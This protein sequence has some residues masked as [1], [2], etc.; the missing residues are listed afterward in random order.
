MPRGDTVA[1]VVKNKSGEAQVLDHTALLPADVTLKDGTKISEPTKITTRETNNA[2]EELRVADQQETSAPLISESVRDAIVNN[3]KI[4]STR[5]REVGKKLYLT[6]RKEGSIDAEAPVRGMSP[7]EM[8]K[9]LR[10]GK[11]EGSSDYAG[12]MYGAIYADGV[13]PI[14]GDSTKIPV[15]AIFPREANEGSMGKRGGY[16]EVS[17]NPNT[18]VDSVRWIVGDSQKVL[19]TAELRDALTEPTGQPKAGFTVAEKEYVPTAPESGKVREAPKQERTGTN[20]IEATVEKELGKPIRYGEAKGN[21]VGYESE[22]AI[23]LQKRGDMNA[24]AH[25]ALHGLTRKHGKD[26]NKLPDSIM[27]KGSKLSKSEE[28]AE[29][30]RML[31]MAPSEAKKQWPAFYKSFVPELSRSK[32]S[33]MKSFK[34]V[35]DA[36]DRYYAQ[37]STERVIASIQFEPEAKSAW[38]TFKHFPTRIA[39]YADRYAGISKALAILVEGDKPRW[40]K[41]KKRL[42]IEEE[43]Q[44]YQALE[45]TGG[46]VLG[47]QENR[48]D[49]HAEVY[50]NF[51]GTTVPIKGPTFGKV[52]HKVYKPVSALSRWVKGKRGAK[53]GLEVTEYGEKL[54]AARIAI[55]A[56]EEGAKFSD[57][58]FMTR[59]KHTRKDFESVLEQ[60]KNEGILDEI[61]GDIK[62][63]RD[64]YKWSLDALEQAGELKPGQADEI[65]N[66]G[67]EYHAVLG[68][69]K[70]K[71]TGPADPTKG[72]KGSM[73]DFQDPN[74]LDIELIN[75][76]LR[77]AAKNQHQGL[78]ANLLMRFEGHERFAREVD[79]TTLEVTDLKARDIYSILKRFGDKNA[80]LDQIAADLKESPQSIFRHKD[81][82]GNEYILWKENGKRR[83][84]LVEDDMLLHALNALDPETAGILT[85]AINSQ[86]GTKQLA[87][88][89]AAPKQIRQAVATSEPFFK[90]I[91][92]PFRDAFVVL[93]Y[94]KHIHPANV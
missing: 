10:D 24:L 16:A 53:H 91:R 22:G 78:V 34:R 60:F 88:L 42:E 81:K 73:R 80:D 8:R 93:G 69:V 44:S 36:F 77:L 82:Q 51:D 6:G 76:N 38:D 19:T 48:F 84:M 87:S 43:L 62:V 32:D 15:W 5:V 68:R 12:T 61:K 46:R 39:Q 13:S 79:P 89:L 74:I 86:K 1:I 57:V 85:K 92:N 2:L 75:A 56:L 9:A 94:S 18:P 11:F 45:P 83:A 71:R 58:E 55:T 4:D 3:R 65:F 40:F 70:D 67:S 64:A 30:T 33:F 52:L 17:L 29:F 23:V 59:F 28:F 26:T 7:T 27:R 50:V 35:K 63:I 47:L 20:A 31:L 37:D 66:A 25:E 21:D 41:S 54:S 14:Y 72:R 90:F 49:P